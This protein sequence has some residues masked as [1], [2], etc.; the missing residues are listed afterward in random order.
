MPVLTP[1]ELWETTGRIGIPEIFHVTDRNGRNVRAADHARGDGHLPRARDPVVQAAAAA[2][3][4]LP[5]EGPRRAAPA[6]RA[7]PRARV[8][9]EGRRTRSTATRTACASSFEANREA[10]KRIFARCGIEAVR[11]AGR[12]RDHGRQ[13]QRRLPRAVGIGREHARHL[14]ERRLRGRPRD[15]AR[16]SARAGVPGAARCAG[17]DRDARRDDDRGA[18]RVPL[19]RRERHVEGDAG[20]ARR[21]ARSCSRSSAATTGSAS[22]SSSTRSTAARGPRRTTRSSSAFGAGGGSLGPVGLRRRDRRRRGAARGAVRRRR[23]PRRLAPARGRGRARLR[24]AVRRPPR[25]ARGRPL[26]ELRRRARASRPRSRSGTS[27]TSAASTPSRSARR[28]ST[29]RARS[30]RSS[31]A[32]TASAR[33]AS[34]RRPSSSTTT[35]TASSGR[36]S[37]APYDVHVVALAGADEIALQA[38]ETLSAAGHDV[39]LDD[40]DLR[41]GE[42]FADADLIG[43]PL[44]V[45]AGQEEPRGREGRRARPRSRHREAR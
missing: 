45:T 38:A 35:R 14:R 27:S 10:Y 25:A 31:A 41:A 1:A 28:S 4:P 39:L 6:R 21:T 2:L 19:H 16:R 43:A 13:V 36:A 8:H 15:R 23:E 3:V 26:P 42:K 33:P 20:R 30:S 34:W 17:G 11:R 24:A 7:A 32:A 37:L 12:E 22:R 44:R 5:D 29:R 18:R 40:R 9:H